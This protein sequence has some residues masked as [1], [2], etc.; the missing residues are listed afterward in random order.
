MIYRATLI[1]GRI[2]VRD[3]DKR[4]NGVGRSSSAVMIR[5]GA[6]VGVFVCKTENLSRIRANTFESDRK[7]E[8]FSV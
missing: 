1:L 7:S 8:V 5:S 6:K 3:Y 2:W 4:V